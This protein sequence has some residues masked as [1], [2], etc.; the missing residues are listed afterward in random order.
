MVELILVGLV[1]FCFQ[2]KEQQYRKKT[3]AFEVIVGDKQG[4]TVNR[5]F[6]SFCLVIIADVIY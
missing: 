2:N 1:N 6:F 3:L 4:F 5:D